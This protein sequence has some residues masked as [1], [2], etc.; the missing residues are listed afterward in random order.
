M[1]DGPSASLGGFVFG[2]DW[3][4]KGCVG[5]CCLFGDVSG[6]RLKAFR[7]GF[8]SHPFSFIIRSYP[9]FADFTLT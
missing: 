3:G 9:A 7:V 4:S 2:H 6:L 8:L 1:V 5:F